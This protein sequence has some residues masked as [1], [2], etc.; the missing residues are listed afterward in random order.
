MTTDNMKQ[1][2]LVERNLTDAQI[3]EKADLLLKSKFLPSAI[4]T[5]EQAITIIMTGRE[6]GLGLME[7]LR[8]INVIQGKPALSAQLML[9][10]CQQKPDFEDI[11][12]E[13]K[14][15]SCTTQVKRKDR[16]WHSYTFTMDD[17]RALGLLTKDNWIKQ[18]K[19]M[20]RWRSISGCLR[21][22]Y[23]DAICGIYTDDEIGDVIQPMV[24]AAAVTE[25]KSEIKKQEIAEEL[26]TESVHDAGAELDFVNWVAASFIQDKNFYF[27]Y[28]D[29]TIGEI[30]AD[31]TPGGDP[32]GKKFL[33]MVA[34]KSKNTD[35]RAN[36]SKFL[37]IME[38][39][40]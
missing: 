28:A 11:K 10:L 13:E 36:I 7:S 12:I 9:G 27:K 4:Q 22:A 34:E 39:E 24:E 26:H 18:P 19:T 25:E 21:V 35:D 6:L 33:Q 1:I 15:G 31:K 14:S 17:A 32:K 40:K 37:E 23:A 16:S 8:S 38:A 5:V 20:L 29:R 3:R 2:A 30:Y